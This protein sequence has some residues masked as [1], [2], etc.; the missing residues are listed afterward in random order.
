MGGSV[1]RDEASYSWNLIDAYVPSKKTGVYALSK[2]AGVYALSK[3]AGVYALPKTADPC[4]FLRY[5]TT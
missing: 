2:K 3:T 1:P 5:E 4:D